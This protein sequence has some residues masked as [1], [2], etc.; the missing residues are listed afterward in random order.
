MQLSVF[1]IITKACSDTWDNRR[2]LATFAFLPVLMVSF[3]GTLMSNVIG[4]PRVLLENPDQVPP[5][6]VARMFF[7][8][9]I[10]WLAGMVLYTLFAVAWYRRN[11]VGPEATTIGAA[12][13]WGRRQW[14][15][16]RRLVGLLINLFVLLFLATAL[17]TTVL[18][19]APVLSALLIFVGL[20]YARAAM[21]FPAIALDTPLSF[22]ESAKLTQGNGWRMLIA[23]VILPFVVMLFGGIAVLLIAAPLA[24]LIGSSITAQFLLSLVA[25]SVNY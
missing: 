16:F 10:N 7:G 8:T 4:D 3:V 19:V 14:R 24:N 15:F 17:L 11:L 21:V 23:V 5:A 25:Q 6:V 13:R 9:V 1:D 2:D 22:A 18:P 12:M 20:I